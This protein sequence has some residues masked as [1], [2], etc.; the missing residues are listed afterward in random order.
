MTA[1]Q[2]IRSCRVTVEG[3]GQAW[4]ASDLRIRFKVEQNNLQRPNSC[5]A[6]I[7]NLSDQTADKIREEGKLLT[8][9]V[10]PSLGGFT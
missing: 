1:R 8:L 5:E 4:D 2:W 6:T 3:A 10:F 7:S 9:E